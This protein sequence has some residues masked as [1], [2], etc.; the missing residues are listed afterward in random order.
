M[1]LKE[2]EVTVDLICVVQNTEKLRAVLQGAINL[3]SL[4][5]GSG[6]P[7]TLSLLMS[8]IYGF[9]CKARKF[10]VVYIWT[11]VWQR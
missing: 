8:Y 2:Q 1:D 10:N 4:L 6:M 9:P 7:L 11:Y 3:R 5:L